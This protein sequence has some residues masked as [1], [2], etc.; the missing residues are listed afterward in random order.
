MKI[1]IE[2]RPGELQARRDHI[3]KVVTKVI[4]G[5]CPH[6]DNLEKAKRKVLQI[7]EQIDQSPRKLNYAALQTPVTLVNKQVE[8]IKKKMAQKMLA[9]LDRA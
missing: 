9:V 8:K 5:D 2:A 7:D 6:C 1:R 3:Y 4:E